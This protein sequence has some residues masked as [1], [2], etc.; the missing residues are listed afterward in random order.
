MNPFI[1]IIS[2]VRNEEEHI[3][4]CLQSLIDQD[5]DKKNYEILVIDGMSDDHTLAIIE[6]FQKQCPNL[7]ILQ[8]EKK[9]IPAALN[10]GLREAKGDVIIRIDGHTLFEKDYLSQCIKFLNKVDAECVGGR[11]E[12]IGNSYMGRAIAVAM[13]SCFGVGNVYFRTSRKKGYVDSVAFGAYRKEVFAKISNFNEDLYYC[14]DDEFNYRLRK[15]G[16]KIFLTPEIK[17]YYHVRS[18]LIKLWQQFFRYGCW[19]IRVLQKHF[20]MMQ[21]RQFV[22]PGLIFSLIIT[23]LFGILVKDFLFIFILII[24]SYLIGSLSASVIISLK[25]DLKYFII[26]PLIFFI[27]HISY[28]LGFLW[29][30]FRFS[31]YWIKNK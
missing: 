7:K 4:E 22:P 9:I 5:Y 13:S 17:S 3:S 15:L 30:L 14:E 19:K 12:S 1:S 16:G 29:G 21:P 31:K 10:I 18:N 23:G 2:P 27:I 25:K 28:G 24:F 11:I 6:K 8:N 26:L 20:K